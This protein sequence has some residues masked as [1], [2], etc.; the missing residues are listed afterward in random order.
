M[1]TP[2][3]SANIGDIA[4]VVLMPGDPLRAKFVADHY[5][6][7]VEL[8]TSVRNMCGFTG[9]Y[10]GKRLSVM[11]HGMGIPSIA[12]YSH[13]LYNH[14][15]VQTIIRIGSAGGLAPEVKLR[16]VVM[17][18][19]ACTDSNFPALFGMPGTLA[20]ICDFGL[21]RRAADAADKL[22]VTYH[23]GNLLST[24]VFYS[25]PG[26]NEAWASMGVLAVEMEAAGLY[27][28]AAKA[29]KKALAITTVSDLPLTGE[30]LPAEERE[31]SF[32]QMMEI[33]LSVA[34]GE[35]A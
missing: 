15:G 6:E 20:P 1:P 32:T 4:E 11:G 16:D 30:G 21:L 34:V 10:K 28:N 14:Y 24:D 17:G 26:V 19:A 2:H 35:C 18:Q 13:E 29:G 8:F 25:K 3:N 5:L 31:T 23:V 12:I 7:G 9:T 22:G 27:L 33:A